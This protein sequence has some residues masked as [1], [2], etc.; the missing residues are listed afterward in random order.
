MTGFQSQPPVEPAGTRTVW[1]EQEGQR[2]GAAAGQGLQTE[3]QTQHSGSP[4]LRTAPV[5]S[6]ESNASPCEGARPNQ[7]ATSG[8]K[9]QD[10]TNSPPPGK[11]KNLSH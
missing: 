10:C 5:L 11:G 6:S 4:E 1:A 2:R 3:G 9:W 7:K 8:H